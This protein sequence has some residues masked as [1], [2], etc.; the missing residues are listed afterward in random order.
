MN[1]KEK[2]NDDFYN[3][4]NDINANSI[5]KIVEI[6]MKKFAPKSVIDLGCGQGIWLKYFKENGVEDVR[7]LDGDYVERNK[8]LIEEEEFMPCDLSKRLNIGRKYD[9]AMSVEVAE[10]IEP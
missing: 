10:H 6:I 4:L 1:T 3:I 8:L 9:L 2:Y 5:T 7:G